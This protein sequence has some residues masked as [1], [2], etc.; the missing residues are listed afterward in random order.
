MESHLF[1]SI[2]KIEDSL[3]KWL[4]VL[5]ILA[6]YALGSFVLYVEE[7]LVLYFMFNIVLDAVI[8][9]ILVMLLKIK[10]EAF[11]NVKKKLKH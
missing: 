3:F 8:A 1:P 7:E 2:A 6:V 11:D 5:V 10:V 4:I 9:L